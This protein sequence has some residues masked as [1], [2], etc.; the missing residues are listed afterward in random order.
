MTQFIGDVVKK[1]FSRFKKKNLH[2]LE[3]AAGYG[4]MVPSFKKFFGKITIQD[5]NTEA[6]KH[7]QENTKL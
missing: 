2:L 3:L 1:N 5:M 6:L 7:A 4:R